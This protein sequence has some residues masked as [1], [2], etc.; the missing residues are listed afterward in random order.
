MTMAGVT[1]VPLY[2]LPRDPA[3]SFQ[4]LAPGGSEQW[5]ITTTTDDSSIRLVISFILGCTKHHPQR[6]YLQFD[7][8]YRRRP[9]VVAPPRPG[10]WPCVHVQVFRGEQLVGSLV[11]DTATRSTADPT[12]LDVAIAANRLWGETGGP[13]RV[14]AEPRSIGGRTRSELT[15]TPVDPAAGWHAVGGAELRCEWPGGFRAAGLLRG[16]HTTA[17]GLPESVVLTGTATVDHWAMLQARK[18]Q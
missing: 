10:E 1:T 13:V 3:A 15:L 6:P 14:V 5:Q 8:A 18:S 17:A 16:F 9:T 12:R 2:T 7:R 4:L 11:D